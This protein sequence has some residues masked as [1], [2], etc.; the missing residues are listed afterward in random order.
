M[1][2]A[3]QFFGHLRT[4]EKCA[5]SVKR[6]LINLYDCDVFMHT[7]DETE[8]R[9]KTWRAEKEKI[10][11]V[12]D[13]TIEKLK[14]LYNLKN[15][16]VEKQ[17]VTSDV[18]FIACQHNQGCL[19]IS[20]KGMRFMLYSQNRVNSI[21]QEYQKKHNV[22]YDYIIFIRP[23]IKLKS[24]FILD[25]IDEE[26]KFQEDI[27]IRYCACNISKFN[28]FPIIGNCASD[29]IFLGRPEDVDKSM[30]VLMRIDFKK[31]KDNMWNPETLFNQELAKAGIYSNFIN[32]FYGRDWTIVRSQKKVKFRKKI[33]RLKI[34]KNGLRLYLFSFVSY[35]LCSLQFS[36]FNLFFVDFCVGRRPDE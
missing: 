21:R 18:D 32:Y 20:S 27:P 14:L 28:E 29:I 30:D 31:H 34:R 12:D 23:D 26:L 3:V 13:K 11:S 8:H 1:K 5:D 9:T 10:D 17:D 16:V 25:N 36:L 24:D 15:I 2:V 35:L 7:W 19:Q 33:I 4:F 22:K 6:H